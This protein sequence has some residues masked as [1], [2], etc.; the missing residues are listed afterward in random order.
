[1]KIEWKKEMPKDDGWYWV[2][3]DYLNGETEIMPCFYKKK[4]NELQAID[5]GIACDVYGVSRIAPMGFPTDVK[6][7][8]VR[9]N[10]LDMPTADVKPVVYCKDCKHSYDSIG[11]LVC[12]YGECVDCIVDEDF[13]CKN[14]EKKK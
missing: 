5:D 14:G 13:Y 12:S 4:Y 9:Q 6:Y 11:G 3:T 8:V 7:A 10:I 1:M 2:K